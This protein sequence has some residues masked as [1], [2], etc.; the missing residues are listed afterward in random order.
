MALEAPFPR[1][2]PSRGDTDRKERGHYVNAT[3]SAVVTGAAMGIG[4]SVADRLLA[5]GAAVVAVDVNEVAL[6]ETVNQL[7]R[8]IVG[9]VGDVGDWS[10][11]ERAADAAADL[12]PLLWW[13]NNAGV[14]VIGAA[15]EVSGAQLE[16]DL[17]VNQLG[18]MFGTAV[19]VR[20]MLEHR[21]GSI[22][23]VSS[24]QGVVAFR[25]Y[26]AYQAAK[27]AVIMISKGVATDY[28]HLGIRCNAVLPGVIETPMLYAGLAPDGPGAM[29]LE[30]EGRLAPLS[31][32]GQP[33]EVADLVAY[34]LSDAAS[35]VT[36][37]AIPVD[38]GAIAR[39]LVEE[40]AADAKSSL[41]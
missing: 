26:F 22:V 1:P 6:R 41:V 28:G 14:D 10:T 36:G 7:G 39:C 33:G 25:G 40:P 3:K 18:P 4:R 35:Y 9:I 29:D 30:R 21:A 37:A 15:H 31:R 11:H 27:A 13:V 24:I 23:N 8:G 16:R 17:R 38:G 2:S 32:V 34:L 12:A 20:R 5:A 19:A